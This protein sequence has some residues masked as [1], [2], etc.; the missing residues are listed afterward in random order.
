MTQESISNKLSEIF[1]LDIL[2]QAEELGVS[3]F[4]DNYTELVNNTV[5]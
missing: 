1:V 3:N 2:Q 4:H 5:V